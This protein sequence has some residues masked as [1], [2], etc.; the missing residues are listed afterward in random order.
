MYEVWVCEIG[1]SDWTL[2]YTTNHI[3]FAERAVTDM[4]YGGFK[5]ALKDNK[6]GTVSIKH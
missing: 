4:F 5:V 2:A 1:E 6:R 3:G